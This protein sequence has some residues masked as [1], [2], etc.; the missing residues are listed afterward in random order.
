MSTKTE[1]IA[2]IQ[3]VAD[4]S[5]DT[6]IQIALGTPGS[7]IKNIIGEIQATG[8][9]WAPEPK[10][11]ATV[12]EG[13][14]DWLDGGGVAPGRVKVSG[15]DTVADWLSSKL[16]AGTGI[17][18]SVLNPGADERLQITATGASAVS[19]LQGSGDPNTG[20]AIGAFIGQKYQDTDVDGFYVCVVSGAPSTW[21]LM[22]STPKAGPGNPDGVLAGVAGQIYT[23]EPLGLIYICR[24]GSA[25]VVI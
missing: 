4:A 7:Y 14:A 9:A 3:A 6:N 21:R 13:L 23:Q 11:W 16:A 10:T 20:G 22:G 19:M 1:I 2:A 15:S 5:D 18:L 12:I 17:S 24:G 25:W 8:S